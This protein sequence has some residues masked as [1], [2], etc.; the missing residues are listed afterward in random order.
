MP[1]GRNA[2]S[3]FALRSIS[4]RRTMHL[5]PRKNECV[6]ND[7]NLGTVVAEPIL[8][9]HSTTC[10][11]FHDE[12]ECHCYSPGNSRFVARSVFNKRSRIG[13]VQY[14]ASGSRRRDL[15]LGCNFSRRNG[16]VSKCDQ[17][18]D[19]RHAHIRALDAGRRAQTILARSVGDRLKEFSDYPTTEGYC[20]F[21]LACPSF[22]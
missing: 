2:W 7:P 8:A 20:V 21:A 16:T 19:S 18:D 13:M 3:N 17:P 11:C 5:L 9:P 4:S 12:T 15:S 14:T 10:F 22:A 1:L 6:W